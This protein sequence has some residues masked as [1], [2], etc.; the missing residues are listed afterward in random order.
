LTRLLALASALLV[1]A[2]AGAST[3]KTDAGPCSTNLPQAPAGLPA[4]LVITTDCG[5]FRLSPGGSVVYEGPI[6]SP[7]PPIARGYWSDLTWYGRSKGHLVIGRGMTE[8]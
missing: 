1:A 2:A 3:A 7:V 6:A 4:P 8:L 5:R